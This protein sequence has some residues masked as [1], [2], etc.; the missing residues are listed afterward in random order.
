M[1][2]YK[3]ALGEVIRER[4][5][6][7]N[8]TLRQVTDKGYIALGYLSEIE[9]GHK[10]ISSELLQN[11]AEG[12]RTNVHTLVIEAGFRLASWEIPDGVPEEL[13]RELQSR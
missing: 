7:L 3:H 11:L 10:E 13:E 8:L 5:H 12:L 4:R 2:L 6:E 1:S 9:R